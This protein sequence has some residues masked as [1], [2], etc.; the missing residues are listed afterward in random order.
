MAK[1]RLLRLGCILVSNGIILF[2][3]LRLLSA[4]WADTPGEVRFDQV[5]GAVVSCACLLGFLAEITQRSWARIINIGIPA[6]V[7]IFMA[8]AYLWL[9]AITNDGDKYDAALI[10]SLGSVVPSLLTL[11]NYLAYRFTNQVNADNSRTFQNVTP[12]D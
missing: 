4:V 1:K 3:A 5:L 10:L 12:S 9:P 8:S 7:V 6:A 11:V 2:I